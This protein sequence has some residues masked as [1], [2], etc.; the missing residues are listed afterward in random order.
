MRTLHIHKYNKN[1]FKTATLHERLLTAVIIPGILVYFLHILYMIYY[2]YNRIDMVYL[3]CFYN[4]KHF[5][6]E[7]Y[8]SMSIQNTIYI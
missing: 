7:F 1:I 6:M 5:Y 8:F 4:I 3:S 2:I